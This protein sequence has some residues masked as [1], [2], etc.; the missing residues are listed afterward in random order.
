VMCP[1]TQI[2]RVLIFC[3]L[4]VQVLADDYKLLMWTVERI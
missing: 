4:F 3:K 2:Q 1:V